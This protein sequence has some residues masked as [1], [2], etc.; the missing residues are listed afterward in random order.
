MPGRFASMGELWP[1]T[2]PRSRRSRAPRSFY[3]SAL[4]VGAA[5]ACSSGG[6]ASAPDGGGEVPDGSKDDASV[7]SPTDASAEANPVA[8]ATDQPANGPIPE[9]GT[10]LL[11]P[12]GPAPNCFT[13]F[14]EIGPTPIVTACSS[15][16]P[17]QAQGG[18][19]PDGIYTLQSRALFA[20]SCEDVPET[21][22][23]LIICGSQWD[24]VIIDEPLT[25]SQ[26]AATYI[27]KYAVTREAG[28]SLELTPQC[29]SDFDT[30]VDDL[31]YTYAGGLLTLISPDS[32][33]TY[34]KK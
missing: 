33:S 26:V 20:S 4:F 11:P 2:L 23:T 24:W 25:S 31:D 17:P 3:A 28:A 12:E 19:I 21:E 5:V 9:S 16:E 29:T 18:G 34:V 6:S 27:Y 1:K 8:D 22:G 10:C 13:M 15:G 7:L 14:A 32:A 30:A